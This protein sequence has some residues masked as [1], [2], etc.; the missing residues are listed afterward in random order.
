MTGKTENT[1]VLHLAQMSMNRPHPFRIEPDPATKGAYD[2]AYAR[3][4]GL[5]ECLRPLYK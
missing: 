2:D 5:F 1:T 3:Y 4:R